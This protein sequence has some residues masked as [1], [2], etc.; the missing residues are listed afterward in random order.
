MKFVIAP[1]SFKGSLSALEVCQAIKSGFLIH[2]PNAEYVLI[3][4]ADGGE[5]TLNALIKDNHA[6][7]HK[8]QVADPLGSAHEASFGIL[9]ESLT[10]VIEMAEASGLQLIPKTLRNPLEANTSGTGELILKALDL[11]CRQFIIGLGGSATCDAGMGALHALGVKFKKADG[12]LL[13]PGGG[14]LWQIH[15]IDTQNLDPRARE[16]EFILAHDVDNPLLGLEGALMYAPQKGAST[17]DVE[18]LHKGYEQF[19]HCVYQNNQKMIGTV[20]GGGAAGGLGAGLYAFLNAHFEPG[21][22]VVINHCHFLE[23]I[24]DAHLIITGE[25]Q[26]DSQTIHGKA[27]IAAAKAAKAKNI[28]VIALCGNLKEGFEVVYQHGLDAVF[29]IAPGPISLEDSILSTKSLL[30]NTANNIARLLKLRT[31][32]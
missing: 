21:A 31:N 2:F 17:A 6:Q 28:P 32:L 8:A 26:I 12:E 29:S 15:S 18:I 27:P 10:A 20:K 11:G 25:G 30:I 24:Q 14:S 22:E 16:A 4:M 5:G 19:A 23:K 9:E 13:K 3:P 7:I 1:D